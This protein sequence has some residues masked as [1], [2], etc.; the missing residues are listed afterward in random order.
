MLDG[1]YYL[2][3]LS[4]VRKQLLKIAHSS[5]RKAVGLLPD[6]APYVVAAS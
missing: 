6:A 1:L 3:P 4:D 5:Y 2:V